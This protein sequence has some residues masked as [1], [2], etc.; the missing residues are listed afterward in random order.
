MK[1]LL[2]AV[3]YPPSEKTGAKRPWLFAKEFS[4]LG[5]EV[6]VLT[7]RSSGDVQPA[8]GLGAFGEI[9][10]RVDM[11]AGFFIRDEAVRSF[12]GMLRAIRNTTELRESD[13][14]IITGPPFFCFLLVFYFRRVHVPAV[15]DYRDGWAGDPYPYRGVKDFVFRLA[16][17]IIEPFAVKAASSLVFISS[18]LKKDQVRIFGKYVD[19]K[20]VV[21]PNGVDLE[22]FDAA[23]PARPEFED[24]EK[25]RPKIF[26]YLGSLSADIGAPP[27]LT[28]LSTIL[29]KR[30]FLR[31][32][33]RF[34]FIGPSAG[35]EQSIE[36]SLLNSVVFFRPA[37][38]LFDAYALMK[39]SDILLSLG[40]NQPQRLNRK[41][42]EYA[43]SR[44]PILHV[45][46][47]LGETAMIVKTLGNGIIVD[48]YDQVL[49]EDG[50]KKIL[51]LSDQ[52]PKESAALPLP[53]YSTA[54]LANA[55]V[56]LLRSIIQKSK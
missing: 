40:G 10:F 18:S 7:A 31:E 20:G 38:P 53:D 45:G 44:R 32:N 30:T 9:V 42:F 17:R 51:K 6:T 22:A 3:E 47:S 54:T 26:L 14:V 48:G 25:R 36:A 29:Q 50:L 27:F 19:V 52:N 24:D 13:A 1:I 4:K 23:V 28:N 37:V 43:A 8:R 34:F 55:Y 46:S 15:L 21:I 33:A 12:L 49:L 41:I 39:G 56:A 16:A 2:I 35:A 11:T 5:H